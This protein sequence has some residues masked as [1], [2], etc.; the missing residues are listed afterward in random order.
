MLIRTNR[1]LSLR[2][3]EC[4]RGAE[5][6]FSLFHLAKPDPLHIQCTCGCTKAILRRHRG[7]C[8][9]QIGCLVCDDSHLISV[10][11]SQLRQGRLVTL[12][13]PLTE[14]SLGFFG[15]DGV[16][17]EDMDLVHWDEFLDEE[18]TS[19]FHNTAIIY[20]V[21]TFLQEQFHRGQIQCEC[22]NEGIA[23]E[24]FPDKVGLSCPQCHAALLI[25]AETEADLAKVSSLQDI[26]LVQGERNYLD[27]AQ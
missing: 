24:L 8:L 9:V 19:Y 1:T 6:L 4:G 23:V 12:C 10:P 22:G 26:C 2:C 25:F 15:G 18:T 16:V 11:F 14:V 27:G 5:H 3:P 21:L 20:Q 13:C 7:T 17:G